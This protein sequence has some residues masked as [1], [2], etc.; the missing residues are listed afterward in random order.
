MLMFMVGVVMAMAV[1]V[2]PALVFVEMG[3]FLGKEQPDPHCH[4]RD[5]DIE[6]YSRAV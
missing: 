4:D 6:Q 5:G 3:V 1:L 2:H